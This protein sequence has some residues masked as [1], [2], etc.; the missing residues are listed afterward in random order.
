MFKPS[1]IGGAAF[2]LLLGLD[3]VATAQEGGYLPSCVRQRY[4]INPCGG[5]TGHYC[6]CICGFELSCIRLRCW[7][8]NKPDWQCGNEASAGQGFCMQNCRDTGWSW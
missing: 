5:T 7:E 2:V 8:Q 6:S 4:N 1:I 3:T